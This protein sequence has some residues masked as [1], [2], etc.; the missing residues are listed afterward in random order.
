MPSA[1]TNVHRIWATLLSWYVLLWVGGSARVF[2]D[3]PLSGGTAAVGAG[4]LGLRGCVDEALRGN[5]ALRITRV[6]SENG[7]QGFRIAQAAFDPVFRASYGRAN[8]LSPLANSQL[9]GAVKPQTE[10][11]NFG[12]GVDQLLYS[13]GTLSLESGANRFESNS[14]FALLNP[15]YDANLRLRLRQPLLRGGGFGVAAIPGELAKIELAVADLRQRQAI[16]QTVAAVETAFWELGLKRLARE[17]RASA[18]WTSERLLREVDARIEAGLANRID[19]L[20]GETALA[21]E[22]ETF[23]GAEQEM[24]RASDELARL[25]GRQD[26]DAVSFSGVEA[27][28]HG[29]LKREWLEPESVLRRAQ[30]LDPGYLMAKQGVTRS[31]VQVRRAQNELLPSLDLVAAGSSL[32]RSTAYGAAYDNVAARDGY[33]W[34]LGLELNVPLGLREERARLQMA[35][36]NRQTA[37][38]QSEEAYQLLMLAV[39]SACRN[40]HAGWQQ[41][42]AAQTAKQLSAEQAEQIRERYEQGLV[43]FRDVLEA[44]NTFT[45]AEVNLYRARFSALRAQIE[46][47]RLEG[48]LLERHQI[49]WK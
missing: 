37:Q 4:P 45:Q 44:R 10:T 7:R 22:R 31:E 5:F 32:G 35:R 8:S 38:L 34:N 28:A 14:S 23:L 42:D 40:V 6:E 12:A 16:L 9:D 1:P 3:R 48:H 41:I 43:D 49:A 30:D 39:R 26:F 20:R 15:S 21:A 27:F 33:Q 2:A 11:D 46:V 24:A 13:G 29:V 17:A 47:A 25:L 18:V 19:R 36:N